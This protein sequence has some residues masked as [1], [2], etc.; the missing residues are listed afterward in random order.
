[1]REGT[2]LR[3]VTAKGGQRLVI[4]QFF[5]PTPLSDGRRYTV[6]PDSAGIC[7]AVVP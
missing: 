4:G 5:L 2:S 6:I 7:L 3:G 1:M